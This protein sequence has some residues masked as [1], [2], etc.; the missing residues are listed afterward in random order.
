MNFWFYIGN[1]LKVIE[2]TR[3]PIISTILHFPKSCIA[4]NFPLAG[5]RLKTHQAGNPKLQIS[6]L[7]SFLFGTDPF[8]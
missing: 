6:T 8:P 5:Q 2:N 3:L 7:R 4:D 1:P